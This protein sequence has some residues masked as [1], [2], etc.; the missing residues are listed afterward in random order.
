VPEGEGDNTPS[1]IT[2]A[3][4]GAK[5]NLAEPAIQVT[6]TSRRKWRELGGTCEGNLVVER[7]EGEGDNAPGEREGEAGAKENYVA[8]AKDNNRAIRRG[9]QHTLFTHN[10]SPGD[11]TPCSHI[12]QAILHKEKE[13]THLVHT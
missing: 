3:I 11:N 1:H 6:T 8:P 10:H 9:R 4:G 7:P 12:T 13:A 2:Q 5:D